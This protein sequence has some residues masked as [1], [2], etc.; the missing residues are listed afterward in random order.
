MCYYVNVSLLYWLITVDK[1]GFT[2]NGSSSMKLVL[3]MIKLSQISIISSNHKILSIQ[4]YKSVPVIYS[5][6]Q[7]LLR[8]NVGCLKVII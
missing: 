2:P 1:E 5:K 6:L 3:L 8:H 4:L 7:Y